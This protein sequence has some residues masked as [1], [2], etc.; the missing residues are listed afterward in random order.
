MGLKQE[1]RKR[2][3]KRGVGMFSQAIGEFR[4]GQRKTAALSLYAADLWHSI[5]GMRTWKLVLLVSL[6]YTLSF[7]AFAILY[8]IT[9]AKACSLEHLKTFSDFYQFS[10]QTEVTIGYGTADVTFG[11][12]WQMGVLI[13]LQ[14]ILGMLLDAFCI[15]VVYDRISAAGNR[16][17]TIVFSNTATMCNIGGLWHFQFRVADIR[18]HQLSEAH[19]R[20]VTFWHDVG[21]A[22]ERV[23]FFHSEN[24]RVHSPDDELGGM[25]LLIVPQVVTHVMLPRAADR[26]N[27]RS[28]LLPPPGYMDAWRQMEE[29][30]VRPGTLTAWE[31][32]ERQRAE[33]QG[34]APTLAGITCDAPTG[35]ALAG[36]PA[37]AV[38]GAGAMRSPHRS[39]ASAGRYGEQSAAH[40]SGVAIDVRGSSPSDPGQDEGETAGQQRIRTR[41]SVRSMGSGIADDSPRRARTHAAGRSGGGALGDG[42]AARA[43][44]PLP[45]DLVDARTCAAPVPPAMAGPIAPGDVAPR[46]PWRGRSRQ[47]G[48]TLSTGPQGSLNG[49]EGGDDALRW[50]AQLGM[51]GTAIVAA[52]ATGASV[53]VGLPGADPAPRWAESGR[54]ADA[55]SQADTIA[56]LTAAVDPDTVLRFWREAEVEVIC[57]VEGIDSVSS[58]T[59]QARHSYVAGDIRVGHRFVPCVRRGFRGSCT[60]DYDLFHET[61]LVAEDTYQAPVVLPFDSDE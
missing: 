47:A 27:P 55:D 42:S 17:R 7:L 4:V 44:P 2:I 23:R 36:P 28:I 41:P 45:A 54:D 49:S 50:Q 32:R 38:A 29:A 39:A 57:I 31:W 22:G 3:L 10:V 13:T 58:D 19:V 35:H 30:G 25:L 24:L 37:E 11:G 14:S 40:P 6:M 21:P 56:T 8:M 46:A 9:P 34:G 12:C 52:G 5:L 18:K 59:T 61:E 1:P 33:A 60:V 53:A 15:G 26:T 48:S 51:H 16:G 20:I 43:S